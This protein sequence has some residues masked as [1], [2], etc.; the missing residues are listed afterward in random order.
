MNEH[1]TPFTLKQWLT[2]V[3]GR[4]TTLAAQVG[5]TRGHLSTVASG[6]AAPSLPLAVALSDKTGLTLEQI[7]APWMGP[8][9]AECDSAIG[10]EP[11]Q[12]PDN[13]GVVT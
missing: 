12:T 6:R 11:V 5:I 9:D 3:R 1:S 2:A 10:S 13:C 7:A 4:A 8:H